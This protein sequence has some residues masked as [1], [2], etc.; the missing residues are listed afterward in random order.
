[1]VSF[2][3]VCFS[4]GAISEV[5]S[6]LKTDKAITWTRKDNHTIILNSKKEVLGEV[7]LKSK[8]HRYS[9]IEINSF[10]KLRKRFS[11]VKVNNFPTIIKSVAVYEKGT[12][13][14]PPE[15]QRHHLYRNDT[16]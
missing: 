9:K 11:N 15:K 5:A 2:F 3:T 10:K 8:V 1:M 12:V 14:L 7:T 16:Y 6:Y 4:A 13:P